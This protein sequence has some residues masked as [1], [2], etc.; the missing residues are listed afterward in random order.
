MRAGLLL[1]LLLGLPAV[2]ATPP[3]EPYEFDARLDA[4]PIVGRTLTLTVRIEGFL[5][6]DAP[7]RLD[8][9]DWVAIEEPR[10]RHAKVAEGGSAEFAWRV[11]PG[12]AGFWRASLSVD[13]SRAQFYGNPRAPDA[14]WE[15][16]GGGCCVYAWSAARDGLSSMS[17]YDATP[18]DP[19]GRMRLSFQALDAERA[20]L[21]VLVDDLAPWVAQEEVMAQIPMGS[22]P[23]RAPGDAP[24][25]FVTPFPLVDGAS[26]V[27]SPATYAWVTFDDGLADVDDDGYA[28]Q[29]D[30]ANVQVERVGD[31]VRETSRWTCFASVGRPRL[32]PTS[33]AQVLVAVLA[34][35]LA[36]ARRSAYPSGAR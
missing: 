35:A 27:V 21:T 20:Q 3:R 4:E 12:R 14:T 30:C 1:V 11:T 10:E 15:S 6:L 2:A 9:P 31:D 19:P 28:R 26:V 32:L 29:I 18:L 13:A 16:M 25:Q 33:P 36:L 5:A 8:A 22:E 24:R 17:I 23:R 7:I 34:V